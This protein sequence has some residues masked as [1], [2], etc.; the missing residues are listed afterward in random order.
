MRLGVATLVCSSIRTAPDI[1]MFRAL[2]I[3]AEAGFDCVEYNDQSPPQFFRASDEE[4]ARVRRKAEEVGIEL[5]SAHSPC[6]D[7]DLTSLD[8][9]AYEKSLAAHLRCVEALGVCGVKHFVVHQ[10]NGPRE[11]WPKRFDRAVEALDALCKAGRRRNVKILI[12][13]FVGYRCARLVDLIR[14]VNSPNL[15]ICFDV[16]HSHLDPEVSDLGAEIRTCGKRLCSLHAH[17]NHGPGSGDEHLPAGWGTVDWRNVLAALSDIQYTGPF[18]MEVMRESKQFS[19]VPPEKAVS[20][21]FDA[22]RSVLLKSG[23]L[24]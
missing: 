4:M 20:I 13:N 6:A 3:V 18:M 10:V 8:D 21:C 14:E 12:E 22:A 24:Q 9:S 19:S 17:D 15:G 16:G 23:A 11:Q 1:D 7:Y 2:E 5:W